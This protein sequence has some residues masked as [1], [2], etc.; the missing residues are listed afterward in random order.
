L[1]YPGC[2]VFFLSSLYYLKPSKISLTK[3]GWIKFEL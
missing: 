3:I 2:F 1:Q